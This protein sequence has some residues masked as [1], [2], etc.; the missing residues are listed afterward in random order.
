MAGTETVWLIEIL[1][2]DGSNDFV[3]VANPS[4]PAVERYPMTPG[5]TVEDRLRAERVSGPRNARGG[6]RST[7]GR[8]TA[9]GLS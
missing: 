8:T 2:F 7:K 1:G 4:Q 3:T 5:S 9:V 6:L